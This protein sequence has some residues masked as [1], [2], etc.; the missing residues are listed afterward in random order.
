V[1]DD[2]AIER[3][4]TGFRP[5]WTARADVERFQAFVV[6]RLDDVE[7]DDLVRF[8]AALVDERVGPLVRRRI[9]ER[10]ASLL[11]WS[12]FRQLQVACPYCDGNGLMQ[13]F[14]VRAAGRSLYVCDEC[15]QVW[16]DLDAVDCEPAM[17]VWRDVGD[18]LKWWHL[19]PIPEP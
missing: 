18:G 13:E 19:S 10:V 2:E 4:L 7:P 15:D 5:G 8:E 3:W 6:K 17:G 11:W 1:R 9:V 12:R 14:V 16:V